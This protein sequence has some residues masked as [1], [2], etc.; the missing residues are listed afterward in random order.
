SEYYFRLFSIDFDPANLEHFK[1]NLTTIT[2]VLDSLTSQTNLQGD[3]PKPLQL[4][5]LEERE[6]LV[7]SFIELKQQISH[8][9]DLSKDLDAY[10][11][12]VKQGNQHS[13]QDP[14]SAIDSTI[15][16]KDKYVV[17]K[18]KPLLK[19]LFKNKDDTI[20]F[21]KLKRTKN[22]PQK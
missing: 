1:N 11:E 22:Q 8:L 18:R 20:G 14:V 12:E 21:R 16:T 15:N 7:S 4:S 3:L 13:A 10:T 17:I 9:L 19:R 5:L 6:K 2:F